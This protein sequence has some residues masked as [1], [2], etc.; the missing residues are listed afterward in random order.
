MVSIVHEALVQFFRKD[1][2][3]LADVL[4]GAFDLRLPDEAAKVV[5]STLN[6][7]S[8][9]EY[10]ADLVVTFGDG[11]GVIVEVQLQR[12]DDKEFTWPVYLA[13]LRARDRCRVYLLVVTPFR[14]G[15]QMGGADHRTRSAGV[16]S[17]P[18]R[19]RPR[20]PSA[21]HRLCEARAGHS[22][23]P[24]PRGEARLP[25]GEGSLGGGGQARS[26]SGDDV[27]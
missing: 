18:L 21:D 24:P 15:G 4:R 8:P 12:D 9:T 2:R 1:P 20:L 11:V 26:C 6:Q 22:Q 7:L 17:G 10:H 23:H 13:N 14:G 27:C 16:E 25:A 5:E 19:P 3:V